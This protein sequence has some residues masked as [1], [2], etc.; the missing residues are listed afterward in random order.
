VLRDPDLVVTNAH[1]VAGADEIVVQSYPDGEAIT[2]TVVAFDPARDLA[3]LHADG[4]SRPSLPMVAAKEGDV[5]AVF[6]HPGG[7][8]LELSPFQVGREVT[9]TGR[10]IYD[11]GPTARQVLF[12]AAQLEPGDSGGALVDP[13][14]DVIGVAFAVAPDDPNVAYALTVAE[15]EA[16]LSGPLQPVPP[17]GCL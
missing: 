15:V 17:G 2:A 8:A 3:V 16:V 10:D 7:G 12:L 11:S 14:G 6:G 5:G 13:E 4:L 9:A 1:V